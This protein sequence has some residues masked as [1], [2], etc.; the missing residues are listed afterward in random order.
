MKVHFQWLTDLCSGGGMDA[1]KVA[2]LLTMAGLNVE[3]VNELDNGETVLDV[4][5]TSNRS[6]CL[7][8]TG[9]ARELG[10]LTGFDRKPISHDIPAE[11]VQAL[12]NV[13]VAIPEQYRGLCPRYSA[14]VIRDVTVEPSP[15]WMQKRLRASGI[16]PV[17]NVVDITNYVLLET[18]Q[19]LHPFDLDTLKGPAIIVRRAGEDESIEALNGVEYS[20]SR[21]DLVIADTEDPI[22]IAGVIGGEE[23]QVTSET[24]D[25]LLESAL[26]DPVSVRRTARSLG[27][28]TESSYRFEREPDPNGVEKGSRRAAY[29]L[30]EIADGEVQESYLDHNYIPE[31]DLLPKVQTLRGERVEEILGISINFH[32]V[33]NILKGLGFEVMSQEEENEAMFEIPTFRH[34]VVREIDL[35]E[36]VGRIYGYDRI[37]DEPQISQTLAKEGR[38]MQVEDFIRNVLSGLGYQEVVTFPFLDGAEQGMPSYWSEQEDNEVGILESDGEVNRYLRRS[39]IPT[40][41]R[42]IKTNEGYGYTDLSLFEIARSYQWEEGKE[43]VYEQETVGLVGSGSIDRFKGNV[44]TFLDRVLQESLSFRSLDYPLVDQDVGAEIWVSHFPVGYFGKI[45]DSFLEQFDLHQDLY[46]SE[47]DF[48]LIRDRSVLQERYASFSRYPRVNKD[49]SFIAEKTL[50][51]ETLKQKT[52]EAGPAILQEVKLF[53]VYQGGGIPQGKKSIAVRLVFQSRTGTLD[54]DAAR[55]GMKQIVAQLEEELPVELR[56]DMGE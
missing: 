49:L 32:V 30:Q 41:L 36:E 5:V 4:E 8:Y 31:E 20:L 39:L 46:V 33:K 43:D 12:G 14:R 51:W 47:L 7:S 27:I 48:S 24:T 10:V 50:P 18:G 55:Q 45:R 23:S 6:D 1:E 35:V 2:D 54:S 19:P 22:A 42:V 3:S 44:R 26:F 9:I 28:S 53:D 15:E 37:P 16:Q 29:L 13:S 34:D 56:G 52:F 11:E 40:F 38:D 21:D 17:N 25:V